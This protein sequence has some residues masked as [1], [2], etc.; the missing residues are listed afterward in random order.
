MIV[1]SPI[2]ALPFEPET[3]RIKRTGLQLRG[4]MGAWPA[5][6]QITYGDV[7]VILRALMAGLMPSLFSRDKSH[8]RRT[9]PR[10]PRPTR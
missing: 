6:V 4:R 10:H 5:E 2:G 1:D 9:R 3:L 7:L 8:E